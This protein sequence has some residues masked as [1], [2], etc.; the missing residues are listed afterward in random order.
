MFVTE[1]YSWGGRWFFSLQLVLS[2]CFEGKPVS[3]ILFISGGKGILATESSACQIL[4]TRQM[5][6]ST[7]LLLLLQ[8]NQMCDSSVTCCQECHTGWHEHTHGYMHLQSHFVMVGIF[9]TSLFERKHDISVK[10]VYFT[11]IQLCSQSVFFFCLAVGYIDIYSHGFLNT[12][13]Q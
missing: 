1:A 13:Y 4:F 6:C 9:R 8:K 12:T 5:C 7:G 10:L 11:E 2:W 3:S